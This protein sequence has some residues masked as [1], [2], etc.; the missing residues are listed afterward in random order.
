MGDGQ[1]P[2][3]RNGARLGSVWR[4]QQ[5]FFRSGA[6]L[7]Q[8]FRAQQLRAFGAAVARCEQDI[9]DALHAD[10]HRSEA[11]AYLSEVGVIKQEIRHCIKALGGWMQPKRHF[12]PLMTAP[13][14][15]AVHASPLGQTLI[16]APWNYPVQL[17]LAPLIGS[18]AAGNVT[19]VKPSELAPASSAVVAKLITD[20][21]DANF[22]AAAEGGIETCKELLAL[23]WDHIFFTGGTNVGRIVAKAGAE[24]LSRVT[25]ELGGKS[26]TLVTASANIPVAAKRIVWGKFFNAGQTCIAPD[27]VLADAS[28]HDELLGHMGRAIESF[29]GKD[30]QQSLDYGRIINERHFDRISKLIASDKIYCGGTTDRADKYIAPTVLRDVE[31]ADTSM[32]EEIF[33]PVLPVLKTSSLT[34]SLAIIERHRNPLALY[35][36]TAE[37]SD[38]HTVIERVSFGGGCIN[39]TL[40]HFSDPKLPFGGVGTSGLG[41]Y[42]GEHSFDAFSHKKGVL[43][44]ATFI[45]PSIKYPPYADKIGMLRKFI[46]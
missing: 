15:S 42:H 7:S 13:S 39:N 8:S 14:R 32:Q 26:P 17:A 38:E 18:I 27:Y 29:Y 36:F 35:L 25:L 1:D 9:L 46:G 16:I 4:D 33:G 12:S 45:D 43:K 19:V 5:T 6:T 21:F 41:A 11:E 44:T 3:E 30:P 37:A 22:V 20:T 31:V 2:G 10:L 28:I 34:A 40:V 23:A 24:H